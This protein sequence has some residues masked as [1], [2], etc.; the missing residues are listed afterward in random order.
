MIKWIRQNFTETISVTS[1]LMSTSVVPVYV[2]CN[3]RWNI[4][5]TILSSIIN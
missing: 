3:I 4:Y 1:M 5:P 2:D